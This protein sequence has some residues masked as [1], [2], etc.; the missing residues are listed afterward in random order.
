LT[1]LAFLTGRHPGIIVWK[2][3][4]IVRGI[5]LETGCSMRFVI[6]VVI[7]ALLVGLLSHVNCSAISIR[8]D[9][10]Q[11][12]YFDLAAEFPAAGAVIR[13]GGIYCS[14]SLV[15]PDKVLTAAHC[16]SGGPGPYSFRLGNNVNAPTHNVNVISYVDNPSYNGSQASDFSI[17][18]LQSPI[19]DVTPLPISMQNPSGMV[20]TMLGY[21]GHG[22]GNNC[23]SFDSRKRAAQNVLSIANSTQIRS[24][25][26]HPNGTTNTYSPATALAFEGTTA[27]GDSGGP[28]TVDFGAGEAIIGVL[29]GGFNNFGPDSEYGDI[30]IWAPVNRAVNISWLE[31]QGLTVLGDVVGGDFDG[32]GVFGCPDVDG[33]VAEIVSGNNTPTY[34]MTGD[35][36]VNNDDL[37]E[38]LDVAGTENVGGPF[39][40]GDANLDGTVDFI[41]LNTWSANRFQSTPAWCSGDFNGSG[42]VDF[43]DLNIW[44]DNQFQ[45]SAPLA[46][47][48]ELAKGIVTLRP[49]GALLAVPE[50]N[51]LL[52]GLFGL[53]ILGRRS[54]T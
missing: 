27:G 44:S 5:R 11:Q 8:H 12:Q 34:D 35:G 22:N 28:L 48:D 45:S 18:T 36:F 29:H 20:A 19:N 42:F 1:Y 32:N 30:S 54:R 43:I 41:D 9:V 46:G 16:T 13:N 6:R 24:D 53:L 26:D 23:C 17:L 38:W 10:A 37:G 40:G 14:G 52:M 3:I 50:P 21:G 2:Y 7:A 15:A 4:F 47:G 39:L 51:S 49:G 33:L 25:F 31:S